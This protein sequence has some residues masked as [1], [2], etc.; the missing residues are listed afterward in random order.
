MRSMVW[1]GLLALAA[2]GDPAPCGEDEGGEPYPVCAVQL[3]DGVV[4][5]YCP[6]DQWGAADGCN[7]CG[8]DEDG[9]V[10]CTEADCSAR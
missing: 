5:D 7:S 4:V 8:C 10:L 1:V 9:N 2:C 6:G 3:L